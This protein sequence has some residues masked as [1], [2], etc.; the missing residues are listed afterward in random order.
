MYT[1]CRSY[2]SLYFSI[3]NFIFLKFYSSFFFRGAAFIV[4]WNRDLNHDELLKVSSFM[5]D[6]TMGPKESLQIVATTNAIQSPSN[7]DNTPTYFTYELIARDFIEKK[8][9]DFSSSCKQTNKHDDSDTCKDNNL[10]VIISLFY[11]YWKIRVIRI[12]YK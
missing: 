4:S 2:F 3:F 6:G 9:T 12:I 5:I 1:V 7:A 10:Q 11:I 8:C